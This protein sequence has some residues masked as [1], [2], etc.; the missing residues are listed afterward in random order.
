MTMSIPRPPAS[1]YRWVV[2]PL[3]LFLRGEHGAF[4]IRETLEE[5]QWASRDELE[6]HQRS[7]LVDLLRH[8]GE[9]VPWYRERIDAGA[10]EEELLE[11]FASLPPLTKRHVQ[12]SR[13]QLIADE[14]PARSTDKTT[15]GS[16]WEPVTIKKNPGAIAHERAATWMAYEWYGVRLGDRGA[17]F[18]GF[19]T[20]P[21]GGR[22]KQRLTA[23]VT[24]RI[25]LSAFRFDDRDLAEY[26]EKC[27][28]FEPKYFYGYVSM[29]TEFARYLRRNGH[30]GS[31]LGLTAIIST[32]EMLAEPQRELLRDTFAAPVQNEYGCGEVGPI[33]YECPNRSLHVMSD[34]VLVEVIREDG[35]PADVGETGRVYLTDLN[36]RAMPLIRYRVGDSA[37]VGESCGCGRSFPVL[38]RVWGREDDFV[39]DVGGKRYHGEYFI[40]LLERLPDLDQKLGRVRVVQESRSELVI[41]LESVRDLSDR[42]RRWVIDELENDLEGVNVAIREVEEIPRLDSGKTRVIDNRWVDREA[43]SNRA[44]TR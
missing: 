1:V 28:R 8:A 32:A 16:T 12:R 4:E 23:L 7:K 2:Y 24:N 33:A 11:A 3:A 39:E 13:G 10:P 22:A 6:R 15:G 20:S 37:V 26:W 18:W 5:L 29:L 38:E 41:E 27:L 14:P 17:R 21:G 9:H 30:D 25:R 43:G 44:S 40:H 42:E 36:N 19:Q 34:N 35:Q 31:D